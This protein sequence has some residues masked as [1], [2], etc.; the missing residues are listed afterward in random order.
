MGSLGH[1]AQ[2]RAGEPTVPARGTLRRSRARPRPRVRRPRSGIIPDRDR[3]LG[4]TRRRLSRTGFSPARARYSLPRRLRS[5][6]LAFSYS[7]ITP[8]IWISSVACGSS[9]GQGPS[10]NRTVTPKRSSSSSI[11]TW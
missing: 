6:T 5:A 9:L 3:R 1:A 8:C 7:A 4:G 11:S 10:R 2:T